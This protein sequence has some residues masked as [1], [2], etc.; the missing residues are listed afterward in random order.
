MKKITVFT[1][2]KFLFQKIKLEALGEAEVVLSEDD[3]SALCLFDLDTASGDAPSSAVTM[4]RSKNADIEIPFKVGTVAALLCEKPAALISA[5]ESS[6]CA[7]FRGEKIKLT[8]VE[9]A[10]FSLILSKNGEYA[11]RDEILNSVW[12]GEKDAG[13]INVYVHYLREKLEK[14]GEKIIISSRKCGYKIN[15]KYLGGSV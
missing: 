8:E 5:D 1:E 10:L 2:D 6:R 9:F 15:E 4:S 14:D 13:V 11:D 3:S 7:V 12:H